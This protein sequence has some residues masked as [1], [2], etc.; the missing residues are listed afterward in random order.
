MDFLTATKID[1]PKDSE[2]PIIWT[3][4]KHILIKGNDTKE[5]DGKQV[6]ETQLSY[7]IDKYVTLDVQSKKLEDSK[8]VL[9]IAD[10]DSQGF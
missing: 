1:K 9:N 10:L 5:V 2:C 8:F 4:V 6:S 3:S 7:S